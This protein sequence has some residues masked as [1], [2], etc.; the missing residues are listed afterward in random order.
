MRMV[1]IVLIH[2]KELYIIVSL[3]GDQYIN[4]IVDQLAKS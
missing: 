1:L 4:I 3:L 2:I